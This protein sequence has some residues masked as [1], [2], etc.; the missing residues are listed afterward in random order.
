MKT[1]TIIA[2]LPILLQGVVL[3]EQDT[4]Y[5]VTRA[6]NAESRALLSGRLVNLS[7]SNLHWYEDSSVVRAAVPRNAVP[8]IE[9]DRDVML[10]LT[11]GH[12]AATE[13]V[14]AASPV[15]LQQLGCASPISPFMNQPP[16]MQAAPAFGMGMQTGMGMGMGGGMTGL[17]DSLAGGVA[18]HFFNRTPSCRITVGKSSATFP[19]AGGDA[20]LQ[21]SASGACSWVA[22]SS[23]PWI[24]IT[25]GTGVSGSGVVS[26]AVSPG[27]DGKPRSGSISIVTTSGG[28][29]IKGKA[30]LV[31]TQVK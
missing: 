19:A 21:V 23:V 8:A 4:V 25:S 26:Y 31:V 22:Q 17:M 7:A 10:V 12:A 13:S 30:S 18:S 16:L 29:A 11:Q 27:A 28:V 3:P 2:M 6:L 15:P 14:I 9:A 1:I 5:V 20:V 24:T